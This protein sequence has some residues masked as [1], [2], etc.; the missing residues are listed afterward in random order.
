M[1]PLSGKLP[2]N[3]ALGYRVCCVNLPR[4]ARVYM[5]FPSFMSHRV[6]WSV[7]LAG[8][9]VYT[10]P[11]PELAVGPLRAADKLQTY[12]SRFQAAVYLVHVP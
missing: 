7:P 6:A 8:T 5:R 9:G 2:W 10:S 1:V 12:F 4:C 3:E 11:A